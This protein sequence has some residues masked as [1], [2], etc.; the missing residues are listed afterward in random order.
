MDLV[1][2]SELT[3]GTNH[4]Q[5]DHIGHKAFARLHLAFLHALGKAR[6]ETGQL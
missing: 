1:H 5:I 2:A 6:H 4:T 3:R